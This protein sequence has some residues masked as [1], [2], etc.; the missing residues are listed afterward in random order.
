MSQLV[1]AIRAGG[2]AQ[3]IMLGGLN[4]SNDLSGWLAH[5]PSDSQLVVSWHNYPG[6]DSCGYTTACWN[7]A[8]SSLAAS[9]LPALG[10]VE[11]RWR[12]RLLSNPKRRRRRLV[13][14]FDPSVPRNSTNSF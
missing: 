7:A 4:Y 1:T 12:Q 11:R 14:R 2:A 3:P 13:A 10:M 6:Q 8:T 9:V 5:E